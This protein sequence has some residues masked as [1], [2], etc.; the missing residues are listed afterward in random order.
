MNHKLNFLSRA[1][2]NNPDQYDIFIRQPSRECDTILEEDEENLSEWYS[3]KTSAGARS[4]ADH[5]AGGQGSHP[6]HRGRQGSFARSDSPM[7]IVEFHPSQVGESQTDSAGDS[8][9]R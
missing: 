4:V 6:G 7:K 5:G 2:R 9:L 1:E 3:T 8:S